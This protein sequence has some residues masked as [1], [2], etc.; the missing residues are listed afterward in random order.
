MSRLAPGIVFASLLF[1]SCSKTPP[2]QPLRLAVLRFDNLTGD[3]AFDWTRRGV[4]N[5]IAAQLSG[6]KRFAVLEAPSSDVSQQRAAIVAAGGTSILR[7]YVSTAGSRIRL[8]VE[9]ENP[10]ERRAPRVFEA[11]GDRSAGVIPL[12]DRIARQLDPEAR[13]PGTKSELAYAAFVEG[14]ETGSAE[15]LARAGTLD[16]AFV[17]PYTARLQIALATNDRSGAGQIIELARAAKLSAIDL[18]RLEAEATALSTPAERWKKLDALSRLTPSNAGLLRSLGSAALFVR[19][20]QEAITAFR[21]SAGIEPDNPETWNNLGYTYAYLGDPENSAKSLREYQKLRPSDPNPL[22]SLGEVH[23]YLGRMAEAERF[24]RDAYQKDR[25]FLGGSTL[26]KAAQARLRAGDP[27]GASELFATFVTEGLPRQQPAGEFWRA[28]WDYLSG[29]TQQAVAKMESLTRDGETNVQAV[30]RTQA[31]LWRLL[32][33]DRN[34]ALALSPQGDAQTAAVAGILI[35]AARPK[36]TPPEWSKRAAEAF[37][38]PRAEYLRNN[39]LAFALLLDKHFGPA[40]PILRILYEKS[41]PSPSNEWAP[42]LG[43]C[44]LETGAK[45]EAQEFLSKNYLVPFTPLS[46]FVSI[47]APRVT[48]WRTRSLG[49]RVEHRGFDLARTLHLNHDPVVSRFGERIRER[50]F[51]RQP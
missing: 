20:Y 49:A 12:A 1:A 8:S 44:L 23:F 46:P 14:V 47:W 30:A 22:D 7:G 32:D 2:A 21:Q 27:K 13:A 16:P 34:A 6:S 36:A 9:V 28:Q 37:P 19:R 5:Q 29:R 43:L 25:S 42:L 31:A 35:F 45:D 11:I 38:D 41:P 4:A 39:A 3:P 48:E 26:F 50:D 17:P 24:F 33:G 18:A 15:A 40:L 51:G 10:M